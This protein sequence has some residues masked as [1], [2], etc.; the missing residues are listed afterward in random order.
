MIT[1]HSTQTESE[2]WKELVD[3]RSGRTYYFNTVTQKSSWTKPQSLVEAEKSTLG[4]ASSGAAAA[5]ATTAEKKANAAA[6]KLG[7][8]TAKTTAPKTK[9]AKK[10][11]GA[12]KSVVKEDKFSRLKAFRDKAKKAKMGGADAAASSS[13][14]ASSSVASGTSERKK[15]SAAAF[16]GTVAKAFDLKSLANVVVAAV[17]SHRMEEFAEM[18]FNLNRKGMFN[19]RTDVNKILSHKLA[20]IKT[21]LLQMQPSL[22]ADAVQ[23]FK[24]V[25]S[26][27]GDRDSG[28]EGGGQ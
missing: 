9:I 12:V 15:V 17:E 18:R 7:E 5:P 13:A 6:K 24:N 2:E 25:M 21:P 22:V 8:V 1:A 10:G 26:Y 20:L 23:M 14:T 27:M 4:A 3:E 16:G 28:K 19:A 11:W